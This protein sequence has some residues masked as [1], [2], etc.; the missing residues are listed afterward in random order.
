M[1]IR[2][3]DIRP[4]DKPPDVPG[5]LIDAYLP[6]FWSTKVV[7][8]ARERSDR[9]R[10]RLRARG[11]GCVPPPTVWSFFVFQCQ[12]MRFGAWFLSLLGDIYNP[13]IFMN[14][15]VD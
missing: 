5:L 8:F 14:Y 13:Y 4:C 2:R 7:D 15:F 12:N 11:G 10:A 6:T 3:S 1:Q 9:A